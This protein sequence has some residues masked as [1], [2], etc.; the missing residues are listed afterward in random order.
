MENGWCSSSAAERWVHG[1]SSGRP[2]SSGAAGGERRVAG[3]L[4]EGGADGPSLI[5]PGPIA[6]V[7]LVPAGRLAALCGLLAG[8]FL[9]CAVM[10]PRVRQRRVERGQ[11]HLAASVRA[12]QREPDRPRR[13]GLLRVDGGGSDAQRRGAGTGFQGAAGGLL[14]AGGGSAG[15][16]SVPSWRLNNPRARRAAHEFREPV[17]RCGQ[18]H[19]RTR[20]AP[21]PGMGRPQRPLTPQMSAGHR[22]GA[23][24]RR[25]RLARQLT[26]AQVLKAQIYPPQP[27][28]YP[29]SGWVAI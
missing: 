6:A 9:L 12:P 7:V 14:A 22:F 16:S 2:L 13:A 26:N 15:R 28:R 23:E 5:P 4:G 11:R 10:P 21:R 18:G 17:P 20:A 25:W 19:I 24:L 27:T 8:P 29:R 3:L 1:R